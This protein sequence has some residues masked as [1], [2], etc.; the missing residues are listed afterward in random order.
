[1]TKSERGS[2][3]T[4]LHRVVAGGSVADVKQLIEGGASVSTTDNRGQTPLHLAAR[5]GDV[6]KTRLLLEAGAD[7]ST[8]DIHG[9][10][11]EEL[12]RTRGYRAVAQLLRDYSQGQSK[13]R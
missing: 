12:A 10:T 11:A 5:R 6:E 8:K 3:T 4:K 13:G 7:G 9:R 1:M 2:D